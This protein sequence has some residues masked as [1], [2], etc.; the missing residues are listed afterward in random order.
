MNSRLLKRSFKVA[1][2]FV[3]LHLGSNSQCCATSS[4]SSAVKTQATFRPISPAALTPKFKNRMAGRKYLPG[5]G[6]G[7]FPEFLAPPRAYLPHALQAEA[8][9][10]YSIDE[11]AQ[12]CQE[13]LDTYLPLHGV[14]LFRGVPLASTSDFAQ[15]TKRLR[16]TPTSYSG[17]TG[18]RTTVGGDPSIYVST[19]DPPGFSNEL[20]NE[21]A[22]SPVH[23]RKVMH[24][25][26]TPG[27]EGRYL[28]SHFQGQSPGPGC[29]KPD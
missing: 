3:R 10:P 12:M 27:W 14:V 17:G 5:S 20:H 26:T 2:A 24:N 22:C 29:S 11:W 28:P 25:G 4:S 21:M 1:G 23:P 13:Q 7:G 16:Y 8:A 6:G 15:L 9:V 19:E 18:N